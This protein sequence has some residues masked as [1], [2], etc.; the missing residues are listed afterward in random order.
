[1]NRPG[2]VLKA[3]IAGSRIRVSQIAIEH[4]QLGMTAEE[5]QEAHP[6]IKLYQI[7]DA[8]AYYFRHKAEIDREIK[9]DEKTV[10]KF[11]KKY[12][13]AHTA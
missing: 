3:V 6:H 5:I 13:I 12:G 8:L 7:H 11:A 1:M 10:R 4:E 2:G 9:E